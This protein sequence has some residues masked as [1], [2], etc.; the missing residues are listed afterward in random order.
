L[1]DFDASVSAQAR[2][3]EDAMIYLAAGFA[4]YLTLG[5]VLTRWLSVRA[6]GLPMRLNDLVFGAL[7]M[8]VIVALALI[9]DFVNRTWCRLLIMLDF[10]PEERGPGAAPI[11]D[12]PKP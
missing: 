4:V 2:D 7:F 1:G 8:P 5:V 11:S 10:E 12:S 3:I 9:C 6:P